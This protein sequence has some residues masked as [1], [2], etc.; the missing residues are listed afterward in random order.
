M[1]SC[2]TGSKPVSRGP[3]CG[4]SPFMTCATPLPLSSSNKGRI[5]NTSNNSSDTVALASRSIYTPTTFPG[6]IGTTT[7]SSM[8]HRKGR[9]TG[10]RKTHTA[11]QPQPCE[12]R[13]TRGSAQPIDYLEE[14]ASGGVTEWPN[15]PVLK[16][17][18]GVTYPRVQIS[19]PPPIIPT[20]FGVLSLNCG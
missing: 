16:T 18:D 3:T 9:S 14:T 10:G 8:I 13:L 12:R 2:E 11:T 17:G 20:K 4:M 7:I 15:V 5:P 6:T 1:S 19:P